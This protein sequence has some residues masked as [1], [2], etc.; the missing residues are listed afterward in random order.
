[1]RSTARFTSPFSC[2]SSARARPRRR[3]RRPV[4]SDR[5]ALPRRGP[6]VGYTVRFENDPEATF[7]AAEVT[8]THTLDADLD[9]ATFRPG[10][11]GW[12]DVVAE[13]PPGAA[14]WRERFTPEGADIAVDIAVT[15]D[16]H[17]V[18][19]RLSTIDPA[20]GAPPEDPEIGLLPPNVAA[21]EGEGFV[22]FTVE[23]AGGVADGTVV[24]A[25]ASIVFDVNEP[26]VTNTW[27]NTFDLTPPTSAVTGPESP[28]ATNALAFDLG[29]FDDVSG[30]AG[31]RIEVATGDAELV[32]VGGR[33]EDPAFALTAPRGQRVRVR[34]RAVDGAG[35]LDPDGAVA[36]V[37]VA[38]AVAELGVA[39]DRIAGPDRYAT[40]VAVADAAAVDG[41]GAPAMTWLATGLNF[42][43]ALA[44]GPA[45]R[46]A[47][48][49]SSSST[50]TRSP[51]PNPSSTG[52]PPPS[53]ASRSSASS[54]APA[55]SP[56]RWKPPS[57]RRS[58]PADA[59]LP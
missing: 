59:A 17:D 16:G 44:A 51:A 40:A 50:A 27:T 10:A 6:S 4:G 21:P 54:A 53:P 18:T 1:M 7:P 33:R 13:P 49:N 28:S 2:R 11:V 34:A 52:S 30:V 58:R 48:A 23:P 56:P 57:A 41:A 38:A 24:E 14:E 45:W 43:D 39:V 3:H 29:G 36:E 47:A 55:R 19:W 31:W 20:T 25:Q 46:P 37:E 8:V 32:T 15:R 12:D 22:R 9:P 42:P 35:N 26:I 5:G